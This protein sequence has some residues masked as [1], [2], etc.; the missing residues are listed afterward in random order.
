MS[1]TTAQCHKNLQ[2]I[3]GNAVYLSISREFSIHM[4]FDKYSQ[5][6]TLVN[7]YHI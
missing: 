3:G 5:W 1:S 2:K 6:P 7:V 4:V